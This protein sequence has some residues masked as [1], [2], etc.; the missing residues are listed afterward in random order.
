ML[1]HADPFIPKDWHITCQQ[2]ALS[3][4]ISKGSVSHIIQD[5]GIFEGVHE[6]GS[7]SVTVKHKTERKTISSKLLACLE[8]LLSWIV[9]EPETWVH[10]FEPETEGNPWNGTILHLPRRKKLKKSP[11]LDKVIITVFWDC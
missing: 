8:T 9:M 1:Q 10:H 5:L 3:L 6:K 7:L 2:L 4:S 11:S